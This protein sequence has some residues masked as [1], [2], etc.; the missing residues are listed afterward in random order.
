MAGKVRLLGWL[1]E[2]WENVGQ[3]LNHADGAAIVYDFFV[4]ANYTVAEHMLGKE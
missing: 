3:D 1:E 2:L 4:L